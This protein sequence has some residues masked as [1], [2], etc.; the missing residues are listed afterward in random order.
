[1]RVADQESEDDFPLSTSR[2]RGRHSRI[3]GAASYRRSSSADS[4][5]THQDVRGSHFLE[6]HL[7]LMDRLNG[8]L[9]KRKLEVAR[10]LPHRL[11]QHQIDWVKECLPTTH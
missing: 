11:L 8:Y 9:P 2:D 1:M 6:L 10:Q 5:T 4:L 3:V 7:L